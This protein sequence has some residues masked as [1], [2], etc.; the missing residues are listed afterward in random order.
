M[1]HYGETS[2]L[3]VATPH[4]IIAEKTLII[5]LRMTRIYPIVL[6]SLRIC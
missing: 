4:N 3:R 6:H 5:Y 1:A 2:H